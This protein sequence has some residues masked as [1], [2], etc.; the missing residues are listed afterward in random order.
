M[1]V[2]APCYTPSQTGRYSIHLFYKR[3]ERLFDLGVGYKQDDLPV[4]RE[5]T[6]QVLTT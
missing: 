4:H 1:Q 3:D 2:N 6:I 5:S